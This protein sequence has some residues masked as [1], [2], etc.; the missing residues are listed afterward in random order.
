VAKNDKK[1]QWSRPEVR[2]VHLVAEEAVLAACKRL[3]N[4]GPH[5]NS[6]G[7]GCNDFSRQPVNCSEAGT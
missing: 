6:G 5:S 2:R 4:P 3:K 7:A 1:R